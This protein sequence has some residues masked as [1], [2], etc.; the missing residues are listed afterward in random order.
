MRPEAR[1]A[2][3]QALDVLGNPS[4]VH[5][6]GRRVRGLI[7]VARERIAHLVNARPS[8]VV[9]T[10]GATEA[11]NWVL[12]AG[13][14]TVLAAGIEHDSVLAPARASGSGFAVIATRPDG[15]ADI[16]ALARLFETRIPADE[17]A[18]LAV[19]FANNE[20]G[21]LQP[22]AEA[23]EL[24]RERGLSLHTDAVQAAGR[25]P[26]DFTSLGAHT[27]SLSSHKIGGPTGVGALIIRYGCELRPLLLGGGQERRRRAG[28]ESAFAIAGFG[29]AAEAARRDLDDI[30]RLAA[31]PDRLEEGVTAIAREAVL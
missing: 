13:W 6:E 8:E 9:F 29:A 19:Q 16:G 24:A 21:V 30:G 14:D 18:L 27:M 31:L 12:R 22:V 4:S 5:A 20:T 25:V 3:A 2:V 11:N 17:R 28:T 7:E 1:E 26:I 15:R 23:A 10:S